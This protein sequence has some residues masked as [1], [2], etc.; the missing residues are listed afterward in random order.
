MPYVERDRMPKPQLRLLDPEDIEVI[1]ENAIRLLEEV[2]LWIDNTEALSILE[3]EGAEVHGRMARIPRDV[4]ERA[5]KLAPSSFTLYD[6]RGK[7]YAV[8]GE[9]VTRFNPGSAATKILDYESGV[10]RNPTIKDLEQVA[11][12]TDYLSNIEL[13]STAVIPSDVPEELRDRVRLYVLLKQS[14][15]PVVTGAFTVDGVHDMVRMMEIVIGDPA[16]K[17]YAIFDV[18]PSP[19]L[20]W[21]YVTCQN[22][23]DCARRR[24]PVE[25][26][27]MPQL[28]A[29]SPVTI[30]GALVQHHAEAL[31]GLVLA[32]LANPGTP[33]IYGG[34]PCQFD[35]FEA[36]ANIVSPETMLLY[37]GYVEIAR[38]LGLPTHAYLA[39]SD[40]KSTDYQAGV[41]AGFSAVIGVV[42]SVDI[43]SGPGML[44]FESVFSLEKLVLDDEVC[45][46]ARRLA[47][48]FKIDEEHLAVDVIKDVCWARSF[49]SHMHTVRMFREEHYVP[50]VFDRSRMRKAPDALKRAHERVREILESHEPESLPPDIEV[51]LD[52]FAEEIFNAGA[53]ERLRYIED[54]RPL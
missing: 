7:P 19:P 6:R 34:S 35:M 43:V 8:V 32:Q 54:L 48:G 1:H 52:R 40:S 28:G 12:L 47:R 26:V 46:Y 37:M 3:S 2:G 18:C 39:L 16:E 50:R 25:V 9:G 22:L 20:K 44:E 21:S 15:K 51:E 42:E 10:P 27:P 30:A 41:E 17:P 38:H 5:L 24:V 36:T 49:L 45:G 29:T 11:R 33:V 23:L 53:S 14:I 4:V 31:S 13:Q